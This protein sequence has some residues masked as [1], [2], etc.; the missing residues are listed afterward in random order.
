MAEYQ[1]PTK[2]ISRIQTQ[3]E[4]T[5]EKT[6]S[7]HRAARDAYKSYF[8]AYAQQNQAIFDVYKLNPLHIAKMF[9]FSQAPAIDIC[10]VSLKGKGKKKKKKRK[11]KKDRF[12]DSNP[13]GRD[14]N[15]A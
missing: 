12:S 4:E 5:V 15:Y 2:K 8:Q 10:N 9:G 7:L 14:I 13:Y 6:Y 11:G 1:L 3:L